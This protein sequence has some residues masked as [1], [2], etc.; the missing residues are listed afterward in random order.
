MHPWFLLQ[1]GVLYIWEVEWWYDPS[2]IWL[3]LRL[4]ALNCPNIHHFRPN[5][6]PQKQGLWCLVSPKINPQPPK[7]GLSL[8]RPKAHEPCSR[9]DTKWPATKAYKVEMS[10]TGRSLPCVWDSGKTLTGEKKKIPHQKRSLL[11]Q[12]VI[13]KDMSAPKEPAI[14]GDIQ[15]GMGPQALISFVC[16][17]N[18]RVLFYQHITHGKCG[19]TMDPCGL[20]PI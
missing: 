7:Q 19:F 8:N 10:K 20:N 16:L 9:R 2:Y 13:L 15:L 17:C 12:V 6:N 18:N 5:M 11:M 14:E 4:P 1:C 3:K